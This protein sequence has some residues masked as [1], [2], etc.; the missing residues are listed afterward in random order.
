[1][2]MLFLNKN[3]Y[4]KVVFHDKYATFKDNDDVYNLDEESRLLYLKRN[5]KNF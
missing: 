5:I 4:A 1:M 2:E 3:K